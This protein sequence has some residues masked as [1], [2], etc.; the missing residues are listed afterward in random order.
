LGEFGSLIIKINLK[1]TVLIKI[2]LNGARPKNQ[3]KYIP[4]SL[5]EIG[6]ENTIKLENG[7]MVKSNLE[8]TMHRKI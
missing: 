7:K 6:M 8:P 2:A 5:D 3:N 1:K 4:K